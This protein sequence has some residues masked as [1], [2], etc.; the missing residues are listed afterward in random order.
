MAMPLAEEFDAEGP[1]IDA[2]RTGD[3]YAFDDLVR[4]WTRWVRGVVFAVIARPEDVD[5]VVQ[6]VWSA[7]WRRIGELRDSRAFKAWL[8]RLARNAALDAGREATRRRK[9]LVP[10][11]DDVQQPA[12]GLPADA[13]LL[14]DERQ[15]RVIEA[16]QSL[17]ALYREPFVLRHMNG[18]TYQQIG[19]VLE[20]PVDSVETRL[21]R[22]R[23]F[24]RE[25]LEGQGGVR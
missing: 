13:S 11:G 4:R 1:V 21:V 22:A 5:D 12:R 9:H 3:R 8:F 19:E 16:I 17:P 15:Q 18:W 24:L 10:L 2:I 6:Q 7:V 25:K 23:R 20:M 14:K